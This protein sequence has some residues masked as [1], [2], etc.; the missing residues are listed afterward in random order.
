MINVFIVPPGGHVYVSHM[1]QN[2]HQHL[3]MT[4]FYK[5]VFDEC[6][7]SVLVIRW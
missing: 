7:F 4:V 1:T 5:S 2:H 6:T 3:T